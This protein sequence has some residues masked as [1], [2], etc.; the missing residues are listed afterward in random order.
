MIQL[1]LKEIPQWKRIYGMLKQRP[2]T[3]ND[4]CSTPGLANEWRAR[5]SELRRKLI[6]EGDK[7]RIVRTP[8]TRKNWIYSLERT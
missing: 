7:E 1:E 3:T 8:L 2:H 4:F 6:K 5:M